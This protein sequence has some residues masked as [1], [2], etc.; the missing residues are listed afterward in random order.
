MKN[1]GIALP[2]VIIFISLFLSIPFFYYYYSLKQNQ[3]NDASVRGTFSEVPEK[4]GVT[5]RVSS[6]GGSWDLYQFLCDDHDACLKSLSMGKSWG[7]I[8]G[9]ITDLHE[10][11]I[12]PDQNWDS[13]FKYLKIYTTS[14]WG[15]MLRVFDSYTLN[16][17]DSIELH[18]LSFDGAT[19]NVILIPLENINTDSKILVEFRDF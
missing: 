7:I 14:S 5:V 12:S 9:G 18:Q 11:N 13:K 17:D 8:S 2:I 3:I 6:S 1:K 19:Y 4:N 16:Q 10:F 15:S